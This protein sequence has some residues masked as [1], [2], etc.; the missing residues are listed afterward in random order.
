MGYDEH[1]CYDCKYKNTCNFEAID[2]SYIRIMKVK[3]L[4]VKCLLVVLYFITKEVQCLVS[5]RQ[6]EY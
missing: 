1:Q 5:M 3:F 4:L 6:T 2:Y